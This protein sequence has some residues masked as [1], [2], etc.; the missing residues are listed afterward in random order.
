MVGTAIEVMITTPEI[1]IGTAEGERTATVVVEAE[2]GT[3]RVTTAIVEVKEWVEDQQ[4]LTM[5]I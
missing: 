1:V 2:K 3:T 4:M 5:I